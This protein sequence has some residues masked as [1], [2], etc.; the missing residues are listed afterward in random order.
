[1]LSRIM[2]QILLLF[3]ILLLLLRPMSSNKRAD[4][5]I[6]WEHPPRPIYRCSYDFVQSTK[7]YF[8]WKHYPFTMHTV[9]VYLISTDCAV[10]DTLS[11]YKDWDLKRSWEL[12]VSGKKVVTQFIQKKKVFCSFHPQHPAA[13][14]VDCWREVTSIER[15]CHIHT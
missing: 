3:G 7:L 1:M 8:I 2:K 15:C 9:S 10:F 4:L 13:V 12:K 14:V 11:N 6:W 5:P